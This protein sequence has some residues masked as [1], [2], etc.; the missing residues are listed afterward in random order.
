MVWVKT[1]WRRMSYILSREGAT[2]W[3]YVFFFKDMIQAV[4]LFRAETWVVTSCMGMSL[5][6]FIPR[7]R[8]G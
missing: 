3:V 7:W 8:D 1:V 6:G 4:L 2:P 5:G